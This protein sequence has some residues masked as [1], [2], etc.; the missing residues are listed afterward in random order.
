MSV[1]VRPSFRWGRHGDIMSPCGC[2]PLCLLIFASYSLS[3]DESIPAT[4]QANGQTDKAAE[5]SSQNEDAGYSMAR[6][7]LRRIAEFVT[8]GEYRAMRADV[9]RQLAEKAAD[10]LAGLRPQIREVQYKAVL[11]KSR[12]IEGTIDLTLYAYSCPLLV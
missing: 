11:E 6:M 1:R 5:V 3:V 4:T 12:L 10:P 8:S 7:P 9:F 2:V